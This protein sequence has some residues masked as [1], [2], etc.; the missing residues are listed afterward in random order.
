MELESFIPDFL[1][2]LFFLNEQTTFFIKIDRIQTYLLY[3]EKHEEHFYWIFTIHSLHHHW[4]TKSRILFQEL[5]S[6]ICKL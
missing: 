5:K 1:T 3:E 4:I 6:F 2:H